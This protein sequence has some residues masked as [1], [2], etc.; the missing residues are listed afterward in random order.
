MFYF[1]FFSVLVFTGNV[2]SNRFTIR[3]ECAQILILCQEQEFTLLGTGLYSDNRR[4][5][6]E[7]AQKEHQCRICLLQ[8]KDESLM[9]TETDF[10]EQI[11]RC[12]GIQVGTEHLV[13]SK[14]Y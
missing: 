1:F 11:Q 13:V 5:H 8:P 7:M 3:P 6:S 14:S 2:C 9:P 4:M 10:C 12:T